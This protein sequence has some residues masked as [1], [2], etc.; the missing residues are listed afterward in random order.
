MA[1]KEIVT[2]EG[3]G[4]WDVVEREDDM[5]VINGT[6]AFKCMQFSNGTVKSSKCAFVLVEIRNCKE[7]VSL[8]PMPLLCNVQMS[9]S[10]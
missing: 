9:T 3:M 2:L 7:L 5:N 4:A 1:E 6:W 10:C 8:R